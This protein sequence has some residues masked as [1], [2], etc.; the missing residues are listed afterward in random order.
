MILLEG[1]YDDSDIFPP[2]DQSCSKL[3]LQHTCIIETRRASLILYHVTPAHT[4]Q[5]TR[6]SPL[7]TLPPPCQALPV[8]T[9]EYSYSM[10]LIA[11]LNC[12]HPGV[13]SFCTMNIPGVLSSVFH[14][15]SSYGHLQKRSTLHNN[16]KVKVNVVNGGTYIHSGSCMGM[17]LVSDDILLSLF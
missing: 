13:V 12:M 8:P 6:I 4:Y 10:Q 3:Y 15:P 11:I 16:I 9:I 5:L 17:S 2:G 1:I 14:T 7:S